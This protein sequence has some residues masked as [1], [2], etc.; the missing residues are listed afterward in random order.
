MPMLLQIREGAPRPDGPEP[1]AADPL[2]MLLSCHR[3]I[4]HFSA[5]ARRLGAPGA[6]AASPEELAAAAAAVLRYF[7]VALPL[8][9]QDEDCS[10]LP[11]LMPLD[12]A[13]LETALR[14]MADEHLLIEEAIGRIAPHWQA[15]AEAPARHSELRRHLDAGAA[16]L[17]DLFERHLTREETIVFP[18]LAR[19]PSAAL[20]EI[21]A[22]IRTR[23]A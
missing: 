14:R 22:E 3:R 20:R 1:E 8:H 9:V 21:A 13:G 12:P 5:L 2:A 23:R 4:R 10:L 6:I 15:L 7:R 11:R 16:P 19:L 18:V 17:E